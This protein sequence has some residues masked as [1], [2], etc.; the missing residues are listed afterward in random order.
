M[1]ATTT[2]TITTPGRKRRLV[3]G[4]TIEIV[5]GTMTRCHHGVSERTFGRTFEGE[6]EVFG[7][8]FVLVGEEESETVVEVCVGGGSRGEV[9][10]TDLETDTGQS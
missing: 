7:G 6:E 1:N 4:L 8:F 10:H 5:I 9:G 3:I 2:T